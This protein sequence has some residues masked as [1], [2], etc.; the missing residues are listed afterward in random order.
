MVKSELFPLSFYESPREKTFY[1]FDIKLLG[2]I[3]YAYISSVILHPSSM[4]EPLHFYFIVP[5]NYNK[6]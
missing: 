3:G 5:I 4:S 1:Y 2:N 6:F